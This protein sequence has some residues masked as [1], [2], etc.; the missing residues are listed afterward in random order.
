LF[1]RCA[2]PHLGC[3]SQSPAARETDWLFAPFQSEYL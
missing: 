3:E 1:I 2:Y